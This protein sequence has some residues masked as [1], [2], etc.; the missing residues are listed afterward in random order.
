MRESQDCRIHE[1]WRAS[2]KISSGWRP[3]TTSWLPRSGSLSASLRH[4]AP[5]ARRKTARQVLEELSGIP[6]TGP[7]DPDPPLVDDFP[8]LPPATDDQIAEQVQEFTD[9]TIG[10]MAVQVLTSAPPEG[11]TSNQILDAIRT[12]MMPN[13]QRTSLS[14]PLTRLKRRGV[15]DLVGEQWRLVAGN[16]GAT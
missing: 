7:P 5:S 2:R 10:D 13:L 14:P 11:L 15:I 1:A 9:M 3:E 8:D 4:C 12:K 6:P 16:E